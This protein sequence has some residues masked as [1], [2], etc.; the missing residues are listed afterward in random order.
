MKRVESQR[1]KRFSELFSNERYII[2]L[3]KTKTKVRT[4]EA[5]DVQNYLRMNDI[6]LT[7]LSNF[8][9]PKIEKHDIKLEKSISEKR[10]LVTIRY[11]TAAG[12]TDSSDIFKFAKH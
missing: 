5:R 9:G 4:K 12:S 2:C 11:L 1:I 10:L 7:P 8:V 6:A 3:F